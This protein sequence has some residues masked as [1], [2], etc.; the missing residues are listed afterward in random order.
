M[1]NEFDKQRHRKAFIY[2]V[3]ICSL[4]LLAFIFISWKVSPPAPPVI[5]ELMEVN[6][7]NND[8]GFGDEQPL[9]KGEPAPETPQEQQTNN[10]P[11]PETNEPTEPEVEKVTPDDNAEETAAP[12]VKPVVKNTPKK[13]VT[14]VK[15]EKVI[16]KPVI[17]TAPVISKPTTKPAPKPKF[18]MPNGKGAGGNNP[19]EDNGFKMQGKNKNGTGDNGAPNGNKDTYG[20]KPGVSID[21][22]RVTKG[23]RKI[24]SVRAYKFPGDLEK[25]T[26]FADIRVS[27]NGVGTFI[28]FGIGSTSTSQAYANAIKGYL[29]NIKFDNADDDGN[30][31][32]RFN[33][34]A[35]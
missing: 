31:T 8:E 22:A 18:T 13:V 20:T 3:A 33:F 7:G 16:T 12:V 35:D 29:P 4:L 25:A 11:E 34:N 15:V 1:T 19:T 27:P 24:I 28:K 17:K 30:V 5:T 10:T 9:I 23:N 2:T 14:P 6:L 32:V 21:G 26:I